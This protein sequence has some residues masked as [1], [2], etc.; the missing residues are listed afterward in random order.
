MPKLPY[1]GPS[2]DRLLKAQNQAAPRS[3]R[4]KP[5]A[6]ATDVKAAQLLDQGRRL[7]A[8]GEFGEA[9]KCYRM[10][11]V[12]HPEHPYVLHLLG[13]AALMAGDHDEAIGLF[14]RAISRKPT[15]PGFY[16]DLANAHLQKKQPRA[17]LPA[18]R[19]ALKLEPGS[20]TA[21]YL[22]A[23][24]KAELGEETTAR[25][26]YRDLLARHPEYLPALHDL[27]RLCVA[28]GDFATARTLFRKLSAST[29]MRL[30]ALIGLAS[31]EE[32]TDD[33]P[34]AAELRKY[35]GTLKR[36]ILGEYSALRYALGKI[37]ENSGDYDRAF[38]YF[39]E[40][41]VPEEV[42]YSLDTLRLKHAIRR[43]IFTPAFFEA[44]RDY[45][46]PSER[47]VFIVGMPRSGTTLTEQIIASHPDAEGAGE[48]ATIEDLANEFLGFRT[49]EATVIRRMTQLTRGESRDLAE[50]YLKVLDETSKTAR[51]VVDKMPHNFEHVGLIALLFPN[52]RIIHC[53]R[54]PLDTC[55]SCFTVGL[56][57]T[58]HPYTVDLQTLGAYY[59][60]YVSLM[61]YWRTALPGRI[62]ESDYEHLTASLEDDAR[63]LI[64]F[65]GLP[66]D[67]A[68][69][70]F[71]QSERPV[72]T[73]SR[74][75]VRQPIYRTSVERWRRYDRHL[76][77]LKAAL[78]D[79][80]PRDSDG[81]ADGGADGQ[82]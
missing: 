2:L 74:M 67:P 55:V 8:R 47:P 6:V 36:S 61:D 51:R 65:V 45:G 56:K 37:A 16:C 76:G 24:C 18:I 66:W 44:R 71:H 34:E 39:V 41:K 78:G 57:I 11:L 22:Y 27:A 60:E 59:R 33:S 19:K 13:T 17:A 46:H 72:H 25:R 28:L 52:A 70:A 68:C 7:Q 5:D 50:R 77:P 35:T 15:E 4:V 43:S 1:A 10:V 32:I 42:P 64:D 30:Q 81:R 23:H 69:L 80:V 14:E 79:L 58:S 63:R 12:R 53:R 21:R 38:Q 26:L 75:Q 40:A 62:Y 29:A 54:D 82:G 9:G 3:K 49:D 31:C 48:L 20:P 73:A